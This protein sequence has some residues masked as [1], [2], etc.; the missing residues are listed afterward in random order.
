MIDFDD[1]LAFR[2]VMQLRHVGDAELDVAPVHQGR[3]LRGAGHRLRAHLHAALV[4]DD[5]GDA[6]GEPADFPLPLLL[7]GDRVEISTSDVEQAL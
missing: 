4:G 1:D 7:A 2:Q 6:G 5:L 3:V